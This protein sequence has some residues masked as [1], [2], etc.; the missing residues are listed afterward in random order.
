MEDTSHTAAAPRGG[1]RPPLAVWPCPPRTHHHPPSDH[2]GEA[3]IPDR[4]AERL[5]AEYTRPGQAVADL[6]G[7]GEVAE[8]AWVRGRGH[9]V[10]DPALDAPGATAATDPGAAC[11]DLTVTLVTAAATSCTTSTRVRRRR[12]RA[13][14]EFASLITRP[15]GIV[16]I[17]TPVGHAPSGVVD[18]AP[19]VVRAAACAGLVYVQHVIA[20]TVPVCEAGL[21]ATVPVRAKDGFDPDHDPEH[22]LGMEEVGLS[23][24][25][26]E[27]AAT[28]TSPAHL[29]VSVFRKKGRTVTA[30]PS[31]QVV[32]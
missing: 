19:G 11:A 32:A 20:L 21:G 23:A 26:A 29:N 16:A 17:V 28:I 8:Q 14:V 13:R 9:E 2:G 5:V 18:P 10:L 22:P 27:T 31:G 30:G 4:L 12:V 15:G 24:S 7:A 1:D 6:T 25:V 3:V